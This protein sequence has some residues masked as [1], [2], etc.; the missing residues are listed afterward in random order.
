MKNIISIALLLCGFSVIAD[1]AKEQLD[2]ATVTADLRGEKLQKETSTSIAILNSESI[3]NAGT[4]HFEDIMSQV[5]NL[6]W[7]SAT[8]RP[9]YFQIRGIGERSQYEGAPNPSVGF[10]VD[11]I[12]FSALGG[13]AT[14]FDVEQVEVLRGPQ[15]TRYGANGL[16]GLIYVKTFEPDF[17]FSH[18]LQTLIGD[19]GDRALGFRST[20]GLSDN[21]AY[22]FSLHQYNANGFRTNDYLN[23]DDTNQR[24]EFVGRGKLLWNANDNLQLNFNLLK[25]KIDN[26]FDSFAPENGFIVHSDLPGKDFQ[27]STGLAM[28]AK[29][30]SDNFDFISISSYMKA[31]IDYSYDGDWGN[32]DY[33]GEYAPYDFTSQNLRQ[34]KHTSQ[35]FRFLSNES[36]RIFNDSTDWLLGFYFLNMDEDNQIIE[37]YNGETYRSL[38]SKFSSDSYALFVQ[39]DTEISFDNTLTAGFRVEKRNAEY[40]DDNG[41]DVSPSDS[42]WGGQISLNHEVSESLNSYATVSRGYKA[43]GFNLSLSVPDELREYQPE[44]LWNLEA[45]LKGFVM[46]YQLQ[47]NLSAFYSK[48]KDMQIS[49][50]RQTDPNDPLTFVYFTGNAASGSNYGIETDFAFQATDNL[51][52]Y[53][54]L[55][56]LKAEFDDFVTSEGNF[57]G[58]QQAHAP[59]Y[60][61]SLGAEYQHLNGFFARIDVSGKDSFYFSDSH[62]QQSEAFTTT[63]LRVGYQSNSWVLTLWGN[64]VFDKRYATRGFYFGL[65][66]PNYEDKLY[67][68]LGSPR[69]LGVSFDYEF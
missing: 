18:K 52:I 15:G 16:A 61:F 5:P 28:K 9:R 33:W 2:T 50:S 10:I 42:M 32:N 46:D 49:T 7:S 56:L 8:N 67:T 14:L 39:T 27:N 23:R 37:L 21:A 40:D 58:R 35:E 47:W 43:G 69:H 3:E 20:G 34:R 55:G 1:D 30:Q 64:N 51:N 57:N 26:G 59:S 31:D 24:D 44:Y 29:Y 54:S 53:G 12:D 6:N 65:E 62:D 22:R 11:D 63:N 36:S 68:Q 17:D 66:P 48:R 19:D 25:A 60:S 45:G 13:V 38:N 4:Q 41:I